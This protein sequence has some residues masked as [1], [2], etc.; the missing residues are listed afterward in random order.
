MEEE[1][2]KYAARGTKVLQGDPGMEGRIEEEQAQ[3]GSGGQAA[4]IADQPCAP[5]TEEGANLMGFNPSQA[6]TILVD[7]YV[8]H[9]C[10]NY[11]THL[12]WGI[13]YNYLWQ[14]CWRRLS[15]HLSRWYA[16]PPGAVGRRLTTRLVAEWWGV[17]DRSW[18]S[19]RPLVFVNV[20][21]E[22]TPC[23]HHIRARISRRLKLWEAG[24]YYGLVGNTEDEGVAREGRV[25]REQENKENLA[26]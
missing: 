11:G 13:T 19:E 6:H 15:N 7:V 1:E 23:S 8:D 5:S 2:G 17:R 20:I 21:L 22:N 10:H 4:R 3:G 25:A 16:T 9:I 26:C 24:R 14:S 18:N 12:D